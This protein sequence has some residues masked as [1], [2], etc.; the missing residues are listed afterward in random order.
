MYCR[1]RAEFFP[2]KSLKPGPVSIVSVPC[3]GCSMTPTA[4]LPADEQ[5]G[6]SKNKKSIRSFC[7]AFANRLNST[8]G[9]CLLVTGATAAGQAGATGFP[10]APG[11]AGVP[12]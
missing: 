5:S 3:C 7:S 12:P 11:S 4:S 2:G 6:L 1:R 9:G 10:T 8:I